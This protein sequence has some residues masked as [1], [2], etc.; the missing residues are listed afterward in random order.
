MVIAVAIAGARSYE[1]VPLYADRYNGGYSG[2]AI[3]FAT[4]VPL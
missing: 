1:S 3:V 4:V 2:F